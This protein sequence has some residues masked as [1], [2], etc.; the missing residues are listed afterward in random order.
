MLHGFC[1]AR[2][3]CSHFLHTIK[4]ILWIANSF[5]C[6][7][8]IVWCQ[9]SNIVAL[10]MFCQHWCASQYG[11]EVLPALQIFC[12]CLCVLLSNVCH[13]FST[14]LASDDVVVKKY[15]LHGNLN[16]AFFSHSLRTANTNWWNSIKCNTQLMHSK[17][18][19]EEILKS[20]LKSNT[21]LTLP[22]T[23]NLIIQWF[24]H[25]FMR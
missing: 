24:I 10:D 8:F 15:W 18:C 17:L 21:V 14:T 5:L 12:W 13:Y 6:V 19:Y 23:K 7:V 22:D 20:I 3:T 1:H 25:S 9:C 2:H 16:V 11:W 4:Q